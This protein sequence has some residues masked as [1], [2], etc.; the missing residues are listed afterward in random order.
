VV[1]RQIRFYVDGAL[2]STT[3]FTFTPWNA[4]GRTL[5]GR[6]KWAGNADTHFHGKI[7]Q[8][9]LYGRVLGPVE[10]ANLHQSGE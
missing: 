6:S 2:A 8:A 3:S 5:V 9:R 10:V 4:A 1:A 7:D